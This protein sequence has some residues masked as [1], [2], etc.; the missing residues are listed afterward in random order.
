MEV[1]ESSI[2]GAGLGL[3]ART[4]IPKET[5]LGIYVGRK[6]TAIEGS[7]LYSLKKHYYL[8]WIPD[9]SPEKNI[10]SYID[11]NSEHFISK[12]NYAPSE[13]NGVATGLQNGSFEKSCSE[14]YIKFQ[15]TRK[16]LSGEEI[17]TDYG[18]DYEYT[19]M[20]SEEVRKFFLRKMGLDY[21][22]GDRFDFK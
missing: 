12:I 14:P 10:Y 13:I 22:K 2:P 18:S 4:E 6:I 8:F 9:C 5:E 16:I 17:F 21:K 15:T 11:G 7:R 3:F 1:R 19:F 20:S